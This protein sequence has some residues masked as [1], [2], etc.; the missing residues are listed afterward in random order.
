MKTNCYYFFFAFLIL[1]CLKIE[2]SFSQNQLDSLQRELKNTHSDT[3]KVNL[4]NELVLQMGYKDF[5]SA[6]LYSE[7]ALELAQKINYKKGIFENYENTGV[8]YTEKGYSEKAM[9][10]F[11]KAI[12]YQEK[13][14]P[15]T[16]LVETY[17][18]MGVLFITQKQYKESER[19]LKESLELAEKENNPLI[20][21]VYFTLATLYSKIKNFELA[22]N[23]FEKSL[24]EPNLLKSEEGGI[25]L[26]KGNMYQRMKELEKAEKS[27]QKALEVLPKEEKRTL[28]GVYNSLCDVALKTGKYE[29]AE[30]YG[31]KGLEYAEE[32]Q[33][34]R[35][36]IYAYRNLGYSY[37][38]RKDYQNAY[39]VQELYRKLRDSL[40]QMTNTEQVNELETKY[41]NEKK[42]NE[43]EKLRQEQILYTEREQANK[44]R[45]ILILVIAVITTLVLLLILQLQRTRH[46]RDIAIKETEKENQKQI[47]L[48]E[49]RKKELQ[50]EQYKEQL[51]THTNNLLQKNLVLNELR[52][53]L[54]SLKE[55]EDEEQKHKKQKIEELING[56]ILTEEDWQNYKKT[57]SNVYPQFFN[58]LKQDF[59]QLSKAEKRIATLLK[60]GL[61]Q[62]EMATILGIS[63]DS[64]RKG[65][66]RLR[67]RLGLESDEQI[68]KLLHQ[69][70]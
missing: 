5:D 69:I 40:I 13:N 12:E 10:Y 8:I 26:N 55:F 46:K 31:K 59:P 60:L 1:C 70:N 35:S 6:F 25:Y 41:Q 68:I 3:S 17:R 53:E 14:L 30:N 50:I 65:K 49:L 27:Y 22:E 48:L 20:Y 37:Y 43:I 39:E 28:A 45:N 24:Q 44:T 63:E 32:T 15:Q 47:Q 34:I 19:Y 64:A 66:Y 61:S 23:Y 62:Y 42:Q 54:N 51:N 11:L 52:E 56:R 29:L 58:Q 36:A 33:N 21:K 67:Q 9:E 18:Q 38:L 57:F 16:S 4:Y 2:I 7:K